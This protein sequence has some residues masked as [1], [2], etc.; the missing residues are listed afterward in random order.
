M[1]A[2]LLKKRLRQRCFSV[3]FAKFR[4]T[5]FFYRIPPVTASETC[6]NAKA[7]ASLRQKGLTD[8]LALKSTFYSF[9]QQPHRIFYI[10]YSFLKKK[11]EDGNNYYQIT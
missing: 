3:N 6:E 11:N 5:S 9:Y 8:C 4:R 1:P 10:C 7:I 2:T